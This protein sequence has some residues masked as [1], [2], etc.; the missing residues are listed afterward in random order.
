MSNLLYIGLNGYAGAGK[1]TVAKMLYVILNWD[2][3]SKEEAYA[4]F[5]EHYAT[6]IRPYATLK[7]PEDNMCTCI[8]FADRL[9]QVCAD[10]FGV[11]IE[12]FYYNKNTGWICINKDFEYTEYKPNEE[13]IVT[14]EDYYSC[15]DNYIHSSYK[16]YMSL[17]EI[18]VYVG[19]YVCQYNITRNVF[20]NSVTNNV[21]SLHKNKLLKYVICTDVRFVHEYDF[22]RKNNGIMINIVRKDIKQASDIAEHEMDIMGPENYNYVISNDGS[23]KDLFNKIWNITHDTLEFQNFTIDLPTR[24]N[25]NETYLRLVDENTYRLC[26]SGEIG[27]ISHNMG[28]IIAIDPVGGPQI[29]VDYEIPGTQ[30][31]VENIEFDKNHSNIIVVV[32]PE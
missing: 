1:D 13:Y 20:V 32:K 14:A 3:D 26:M 23:Y 29:L 8:A 27:R 24:T 11:P 2:W 4:K 16:Y 10:I 30:F 31:V 19:T 12:Y 15:K 9:K 22:I 21:K 28:K 7:N 5:T 25:E 6:N 18:L 17:R